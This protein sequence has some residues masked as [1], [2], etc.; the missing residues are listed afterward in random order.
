MQEV[1]ALD[2]RRV[3]VGEQRKI[4]MHLLRVAAINLHRIDA[5]GGNL[6]PARL[7]IAKT[8]L[9]TPQLGVTKRSPMSAVKD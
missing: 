5:N 1:V 2:Y 4:K 6:H 8:L 3:R 7:E 9:E